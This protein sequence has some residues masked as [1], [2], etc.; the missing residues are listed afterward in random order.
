[1]EIQELSGHARSRR[2]TPCELVELTIEGIRAE[3]CPAKASVPCE[4]C[5]DMVRLAEHKGVDTQYTRKVPLRHS[6]ETCLLIGKGFAT[7]NAPLLSKFNILKQDPSP[8]EDLLADQW[9]LRGRSSHYSASRK[10]GAPTGTKTGSSRRPSTQ[11]HQS[12]KHHQECTKSG[13]KSKTDFVSKNSDFQAGCFRSAVS[14]GG[15][16]M[17]MGKYSNFF[18]AKLCVA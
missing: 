15:L 16:G 18:K 4:V 10:K 14:S 7:G 6:T 13:L 3:A 12:S 2:W 5:S 8:G 1:M 9:R 17:L 11:D